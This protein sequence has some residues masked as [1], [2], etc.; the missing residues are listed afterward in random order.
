MEAS[1]TVKHGHK[2]LYYNMDVHCG[3]TGTSKLGAGGEYQGIV[4]IYN[5]SHETSF[6]LGGDAGTCY[7]YQLGWSSESQQH[8]GEDW[9]EEIRARAH[10]LF[11]LVADRIDVVVKELKQK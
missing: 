10:D 7:L 3:W 8:D 4:R 6:N 5:V 11:D 2:S 1:V 9:A